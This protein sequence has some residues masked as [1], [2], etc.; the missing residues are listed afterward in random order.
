MCNNPFRKVLR[1]EEAEE[2][3]VEV[4]MV[5]APPAEAAG[6]EAVAAVVVVAAAGWEAVDLRAAMR[7]ETSGE[8]R[9]RGNAIGLKWRVCLR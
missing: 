8:N 9:V 5:G 3:E 6:S 7:E 4:A 2:E 1:G